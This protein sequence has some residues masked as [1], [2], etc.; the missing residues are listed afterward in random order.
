MTPSCLTWPH[1]GCSDGHC[2]RAVPPG[3]VSRF[4]ARWAGRIVVGVLLASGLVIA[5][6]I[7][8]AC[9]GGHG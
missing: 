9:G 2:A 7:C 8:A 5:W 3:P 4:M 6:G 1:C